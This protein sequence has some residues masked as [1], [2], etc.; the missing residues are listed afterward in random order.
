MSPVP[1]MCERRYFTL[2]ARTPLGIVYATDAASDPNVEIVGIFPEDTHPRIIYPIAV[3]A[4]SKK[5]RRRKI[6]SLY[7]IADG[8]AGFRKAGFYGA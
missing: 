5:F 1:R 7:K 3:T 2:T 6:P 8:E 4:A